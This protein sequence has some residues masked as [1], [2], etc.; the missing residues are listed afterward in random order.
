MRGRLI[1][2]LKRLDAILPQLR[3]PTAENVELGDVSTFPKQEG[4]TQ[5]CC[6]GNAS[7][8]H[9]GSTQ[10]GQRVHRA[11]V[12]GSL[13]LRPMRRDLA[14]KAKGLEAAERLL[15]LPEGLQ[16]AKR[17]QVLNCTDHSARLLP[18]QGLLA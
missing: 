4:L 15:A 11:R 18:A 16:P 8:L 5:V 14:G 10:E 3:N 1:D 9:Q 7:R 6:Y 12:A 2:R 13:A 17:R